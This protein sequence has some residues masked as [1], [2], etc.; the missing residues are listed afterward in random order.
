MVV[1]STVS[2]RNKVLNEIAFKNNVVR[3][4]THNIVLICGI[5]EKEREKTKTVGLENYING[6]LITT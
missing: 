5:P 4:D 3:Y 6:R 1:Y 2:P